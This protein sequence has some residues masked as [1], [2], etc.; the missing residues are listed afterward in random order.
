LICIALS[1]PRESQ[2]PNVGLITLEDAESGECVEVDSGNV[3][4]RQRYQSQARQRRDA[5]TKQMRQK[6]LD[7]IEA[8]TDQ[9]YLPALRQL[10]AR[11]ATRH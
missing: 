9:P 3:K 6:G 4:F 2:L 5:F 11:R 8:R 7:W 1:D 10:F